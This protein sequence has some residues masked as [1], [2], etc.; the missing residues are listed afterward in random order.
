MR[1][2]SIER[3]TVH[4]SGVGFWDNRKAPAR[5]RSHQANHQARGWPDI[6]YHLLIDRRGHVYRGRPLWARG[7][8]GTDYNPRGHLLV[9][10]EGNFEKQKPTDAQVRALVHVLAWACV[11]Y[12]LPLRRIKGHRDFANTACPGDALYR[13]LENGTIRRRVRRRINRGG[14]SLRKICGDAGDRLVARIE[15]GDA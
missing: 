3:V 14:V 6:A 8:T 2:H 5:F 13:L 15:S 10:C 9:M 1:A 11:T 4:H 7:D 12:D